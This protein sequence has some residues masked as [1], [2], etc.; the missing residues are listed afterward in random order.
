VDIGVSNAHFPCGMAVV[1]VDS[2]KKSYLYYSAKKGGSYHLWKVVKSGDTWAA[3]KKLDT[4]GDLAETTQ[5]TATV[6]TGSKKNYIVFTTDD[7]AVETV[8]DDW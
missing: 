8:Q 6:L 1:R 5:I 3:A 4:D 2:E 7:G